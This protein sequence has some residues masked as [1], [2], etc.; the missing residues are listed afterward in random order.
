MGTLDSDHITVTCTCGAKLR[1]RHAAIYDEDNERMVIFGGDDGGHR[2]DVW[3]MSLDTPG[4]ETWSALAP[5]GDVEGT[6]DLFAYQNEM[7]CDLS[8]GGGEDRGA[9]RNAPS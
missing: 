8:P 7:G 3:A 6:K 2:N 9:C 5:G 1:A 4:A